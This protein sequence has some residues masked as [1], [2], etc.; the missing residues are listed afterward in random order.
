MT[1]ITIPVFR[2]GYAGYFPSVSRKIGDIG[3]FLQVPDLHNTAIKMP[4]LT[5]EEEKERED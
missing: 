4:R 1:E 3:A 5:R 2:E